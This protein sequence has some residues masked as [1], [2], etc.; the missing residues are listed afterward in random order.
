VKPFPKDR[1]KIGDWVRVDARVRFER[2]EAKRAELREPVVGQV[3]GVALRCYGQYDSGGPTN[4]NED[5]EPP[6]LIVAETEY[7]WLVRAG[8]TNKPIEVFDA[9]VEGC[10]GEKALPF[11]RT[12]TMPWS[13]KDKQELRDIMHTAARDKKGRWLPT[14]EWPK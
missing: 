9:D 4:Y 10:W 1:F 5:Y 3:V 8:M 2:G 7:V 14:S 12:Q 13:E 11:R 6:Y